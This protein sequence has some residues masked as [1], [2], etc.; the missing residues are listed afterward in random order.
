MMCRMAP[1]AIQ[2]ESL[3]KTYRGG[4]CALLDV[5]LEVRVGEVFGFL[6]PNGA[7]KTTLIRTLL[8]LQRPTAGSARVLGLDCRRDSVA[9]HRHVGYLPGDLR[10]RAHLTGAEQ[11]RSFRL[12]R[13][14]GHADL[15]RGLAERFGADLGRRIGDLSKGNRQKLGLVAAFMHRPQVVI[16]DEPTS[17]LDPLVQEE[18]RE[19]VRETAA[20]GRTVFLSSH[21]LDEV[22]HVADRVGIVR[23]GR[24]VATEAVHDLLGRAV[25]HLAVTFAEPVGA[26]RF[27]HLDG[28]TVVQAHERLLRLTVRGPMRELVAELARHPVVDLVSTP[29]DLEEIFL[30]YYRDDADVG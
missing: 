26:E 4:V 22:Q 24:L 2:T 15:E 16:L 11:L 5:D 30:T 20:E 18:F 3:S 6:G 21:S 14:G 1:A 17:G 25:R 13:G 23:A 19:V 12:M 29:A 27:G 10:M 8:D 9:V 7:G 28:V